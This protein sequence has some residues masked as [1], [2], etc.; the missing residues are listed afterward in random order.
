MKVGDRL[1][2]RDQDLDRTLGG[3][4]VIDVEAPPGRRR[5]PDR[6]DRIATLRGASPDDALAALARRDAVPADTFRNNWNLTVR[7]P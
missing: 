7:M 6:L 4:T 3:G 2:L 5:A 1:I